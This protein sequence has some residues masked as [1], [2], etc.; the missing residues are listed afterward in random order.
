M[1][2]LEYPSDAALQAQDAEQEAATA[3]ERPAYAP[4]SIR[5][6]DYNQPPPF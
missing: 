4:R 3:D 1:E 2:E 5:L 6:I